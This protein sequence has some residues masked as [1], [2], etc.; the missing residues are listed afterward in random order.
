[1]ASSLGPN[2]TCPCFPKKSSTTKSR[3]TNASILVSNLNSPWFQNELNYKVAQDQ[4]SSPGFTLPMVS[5]RCQLQSCARWW[6][7]CWIQISP[8]PDIKAELNRKVAQ[9][10]GIA[11][12]IYFIF[13]YSQ[14]K[15]NR[16]ILRDKGLN[17]GIKF[18]QFSTSKPSSTKKS[19]V[20]K[21]SILNANFNTV[22]GF[23][24]LSNYAPGSFLLFLK[25]V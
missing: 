21:A 25:R 22:L 13:P 10:E 9:D 2:F 19:C 23:K 16:K 1:M 5:K 6:L 11:P 8:A 12:G 18:K 20:I 3:K 24:S 15:F 14:D 4:G 17:S 7:W